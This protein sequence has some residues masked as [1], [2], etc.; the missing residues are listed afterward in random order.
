MKYRLRF[1]GDHP[2]HPSG[3]Q[4]EGGIQGL[5]TFHRQIYME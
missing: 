2:V 4:F 5:Q 1:D 3:S